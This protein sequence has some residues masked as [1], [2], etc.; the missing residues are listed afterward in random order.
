M[1]E[2]RLTAVGVLGAVRLR[3]DKR[4]W[5]RRENL[6]MDSL[7]RDARERKELVLLK[8]SAPSSSRPPLSTELDRKLNAP[9]RERRTFPTHPDTWEW[10]P[11]S[12][13]PRYSITMLCW[14]N[15]GFELSCDSCNRSSRGT[16]EVERQQSGDGVP[17]LYW[18]RVNAAAARKVMERAMTELIHSQVVMQHGYRKSSRDQDT[19]SFTRKASFCRVVP[20]EPPGFLFQHISVKAPLGLPQLN[21]GSFLMSI[22][23]L[24]RYAC[25]DI[26]VTTHKQQPRGYKRPE[27]LIKDTSQT[28]SRPLTGFL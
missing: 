20:P 28:A 22:S 14:L 26:S 21:M 23:M 27:L 17:G 15:R 7:L 2:W 11:D 1:C 25:Y 6:R 12:L 10:A 19:S 24:T 4:C 3:K 13:S 8:P 9:W 18:R 16:L 5:L